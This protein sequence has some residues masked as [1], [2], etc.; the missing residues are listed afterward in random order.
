MKAQVFG[1]LTEVVG[2][3]STM[4]TKYHEITFLEEMQ[5]T[6]DGFEIK[7]VEWK[8]CYYPNVI[9]HEHLMKMIDKKVIVE[10]NF[11]VVSRK[12]GDKFYQDIKMNISDVA[13]VPDK[14]SKK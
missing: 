9:N 3:V 6:P 1:R 12:Q 14:E 11:Y 8:K 10:A 4:G 7:P 2:K 5:P 13:L